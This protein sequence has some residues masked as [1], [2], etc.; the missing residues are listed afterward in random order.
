MLFF[1]VYAL[2]SETPSPPELVEGIE[3]DG[4]RFIDK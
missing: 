2:I 4:V 1:F 3:R